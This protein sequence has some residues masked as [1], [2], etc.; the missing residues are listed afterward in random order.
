MKVGVM[1]GSLREFDLAEVLQVVGIGRQYTGIELRLSNGVVGTIFVKSGQVV[2][3]TANDSAGPNAFFNLFQ[4]ADGRFF[5]FR[6][7]T[8]KELPEPLGPLHRLLM[9]VPPP[10]PAKSEPVH[11]PV[12]PLASYEE[13]ERPT[14]TGVAPPSEGAPSPQEAPLPKSAMKATGTYRPPAA[15]A[16][17]TNGKPARTIAV[18]SPKGGCGKST[19]ALN[20]SLSLARRGHSVVLVDADVN[21][22][23]LSAIN[24]RE[25]A[26]IGALDVLYDDAPLDEALLETVMTR[27]KI[28]PAVGARLPDPQLIANDDHERWGKLLSELGRRAEVVVVDTPAGMFGP[29]RAVLANASHVLGVLQAEVIAARSFA[30]FSQG[31]ETL[32]PEQRPS[33]LGVVLNMLQTRH[34]A[35]LGVFQEALQ[36]LP[37]EWLFDTTI[38]R[39]PAFLEA[40]HQGLPLRHLDDEAPPPVAFLF[41]N[42]AGELAG[43]LELLAPEARPRPFLL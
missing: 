16:A 35:S 3:A 26:T 27:L 24:A 38:P 41:D 25:K 43:R 17:N 2:S 13:R 14:Q 15:A 39:H 19:I 8:P 42:L 28:L 40:T 31:L 33:V 32:R 21:G 37:S 7:E 22:D 30:R 23:V 36:E 1:Q 4:A 12:V 20:L 29:T 18:V 11:A 9:E 34:H 5:V 6:T 10:R